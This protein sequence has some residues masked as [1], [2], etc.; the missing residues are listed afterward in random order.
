MALEFIPTRLDQARSAEVD[1]LIKRFRAE[2]AP[3]GIADGVLY[4][5]W[6]K[7][8]D[9]D[10]VRHSVDLALVS[11]KTGLVFIRVLAATNS[12]QVAE[13]AESLSQATAGAMAQLL[14]SARLRS[15]GRQLQ[16]RVTPI[17]FT[18]GFH[19][20]DAGEVEI[21]V[22]E[23][24]VLHEVAYRALRWIA[25]SPF[26]LLLLLPLIAVEYLVIAKLFGRL[27]EWTADRET[28]RQE[29]NR[30]R[31]DPHAPRGIR[32]DLGDR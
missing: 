10:A 3:L 27:G 8:T 19:A 23:L 12:K 11:A 2:E 18:P 16:V 24:L 9:Y 7:Y 15:R 28:A 31:P 32:E 25:D 26:W 13:T 29:R 21:F 20:E 5:G 17:L 4:Y 1:A 14:R 6:P 22:S 30:T